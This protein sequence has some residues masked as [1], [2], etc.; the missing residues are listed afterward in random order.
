MSLQEIVVVIGNNKHKSHESAVCQVKFR[1]KHQ[2]FQRTLPVLIFT[3]KTKSFKQSIGLLCV[4]K[5]TEKDSDAFHLSNK[6]YSLFMLDSINLLPYKRQNFLKMYFETYRCPP[7]PWVVQS[8]VI[9]VLQAAGVWHPGGV[10]HL[11]PVCVVGDSTATKLSK[12]IKNK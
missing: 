7:C 8:T 3:L 6:L 10:V 9:A 11:K 12:K 1:K 2:K 5:Y 4:I